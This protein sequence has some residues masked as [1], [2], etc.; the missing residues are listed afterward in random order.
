MS[1]RNEENCLPGFNLAVV[2]IDGGTPIATAEIL[3]KNYKYLLY[4]T[5]RHTNK[6]NRYRIIFP[7]SHIIKLTA[8]DY[9]EFMINFYD[10][11]PFDVDR[12]TNQRSRKWLAN[13]NKKY[14]PKYNDGELIDALLFIPK[15]SKLENRKKILNKQQNLSN[16]EKWVINTSEEQGRNN[17][18]LKYAFALVDIGLNIHDIHDKL[19][20]LNSKLPNKLSEIEI[21][22]TIMV[23]ASAKIHKRDTDI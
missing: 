3:L 12:Q 18:L 15:T 5:K 20:M 6:V 10:W 22:S 19:L 7:L 2:D 13:V 16:L 14:P 1:R 21:S 23:S 17:Q 8:K 9:K 11:L 4:T